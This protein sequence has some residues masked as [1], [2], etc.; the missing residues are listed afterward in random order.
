MVVYNFDILFSILFPNLQAFQ[1]QL[2]Q[3]RPYW[4]CQWA[5]DHQESSSMCSQERHGRQ[6]SAARSGSSWQ[7]EQQDGHGPRAP[8]W[9][10][11]G[12]CQVHS[13]AMLEQCLTLRGFGLDEAISC[14]QSVRA[15]EPSV[16][17]GSETHIVPGLGTHM[18]M[19][20]TH[21]TQ[22]CA[23]TDLSAATAIYIYLDLP[24]VFG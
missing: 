22:N 1:A 21:S 24:T 2:E 10:T 20:H 4:V 7:H 15:V 9:K 14:Y 23:D 18:L 5:G 17:M 12:P 11:S 16:C 3:L 6:N 8:G 19:A 13:S